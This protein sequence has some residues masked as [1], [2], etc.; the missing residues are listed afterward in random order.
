[1]P[2]LDHPTHEKTIAAAVARS[3][4]SPSKIKRKSGFQE[5]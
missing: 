3:I 5:D 2:V 1:M 4:E